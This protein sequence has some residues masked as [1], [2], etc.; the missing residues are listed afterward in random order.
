MYF[1]VFEYPNFIEECM[2]SDSWRSFDWEER[3][4]CMGFLTYRVDVPRLYA[5]AEPHWLEDHEFTFFVLRY[6]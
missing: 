4:K 5:G 6:S 1:D 2:S 3:F